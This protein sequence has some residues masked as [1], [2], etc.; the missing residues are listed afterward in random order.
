MRAPLATGIVQALPT[1]SFRP[2]H[3]ITRPATRVT[4]PETCIGSTKSSML[5]QSFR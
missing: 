5:P 2:T 1:A 4:R 3:S